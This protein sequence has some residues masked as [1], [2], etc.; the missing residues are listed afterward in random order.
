MPAQNVELEIRKLD[1]GDRLTGVSVGAQEY[2]PLKTF[3]QSSAKIYHERH[4]AKTYVGAI[5]GRIIAYITL[6]CAEIVLEGDA[7]RIRE[8]G[9]YYNYKSYPAIKIA[10]LLVD[11]RFRGQDI[12]EALVKL[13]LGTA[14]DAICPVVGCRFVVVDS[15]KSSVPFYSKQGFTLLDTPDNKSRPE[16]VMFVDLHK[17][18]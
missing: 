3:L 18:A 16:P 13:A 6:L 5:N 10:R 15:K 2:V 7:Y 9:L 14:K 11:S 8:P 17:A 4:L 1:P 12:G